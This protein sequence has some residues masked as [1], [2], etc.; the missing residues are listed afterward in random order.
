MRRLAV[1]CST[2]SSPHARGARSSWSGTFDPPGLIPACAGSTYMLRHCRPLSRAHPRMRGEHATSSRWFRVPGGSSP[3]ARGARGRGPRPRPGRGL[4]PA[5][6][7]STMPG[8]STSPTRPAHPRMRGEHD[9]R[10]I[11]P[12]IRLGSSPHARGARAARSSTVGPRSAHPRMRGEHT[13]HSYDTKV[14]VGSSPHARG[15]RDLEPDHLQALRLIPACAGSTRSAGA[16][17]LA[18]VAHPRMRGEH[19]PQQEKRYAATGSSPHARGALG[20]DPQ[21]GDVQ[22]LIP[23]C[24]GSTPA[25][26][27]CCRSSGAHPRMRGEHLPTRLGLLWGYGSSPHARGAHGSPADRHLWG[28]LIPA[29]AGSTSSARAEKGIR[30]AHP[31]MRG[32]HWD[33]A[34]KVGTYNGSSPH[35]RGARRTRGAGGPR[36]GLIPACAGSTPQGPGPP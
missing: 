8:T 13:L 15:A 10:P 9:I 4:I 5:C 7:G 25:T 31:R 30:R 20:P 36:C 18:R 35:A 26:G 29:C 6:A 11:D 28:G 24:A 23:A 12:R 1:A 19:G 21:G 16:A 22:R 33:K 34:P 27:G 14:A 17:D 2:G 32:E 3:H